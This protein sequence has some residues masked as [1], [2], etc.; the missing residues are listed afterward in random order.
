MQLKINIR[1]ALTGHLIQHVSLSMEILNRFF[2]GFIM[3]MQSNFSLSDSNFMDMTVKCHEV[4]N[5]IL[6]QGDRF[7]FMLIPYMVT[8]SVY[9]SLS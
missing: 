8:D 7:P 4:Y 3:E 2:L 1:Q 9:I 5:C 6:V